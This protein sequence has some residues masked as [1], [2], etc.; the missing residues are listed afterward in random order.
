MDLKSLYTDYK[1]P[2]AFRGERAFY[3]YVKSKY[4]NA[5]KSQVNKFLV[6]NDAYTLHVPKKKIKKY[7]RIY[8]KGIFY[9]LQIDLVDLLK[10]KKENRGYAYTLNIIGRT[11]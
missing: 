6:S 11:F 5:T 10:Y 9:Q 3:R 4:P 7:R 1:N 2:G 8:V